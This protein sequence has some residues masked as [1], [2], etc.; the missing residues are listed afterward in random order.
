[1]SLKNALLGLLSST[2]LNGY[3][4]KLLFNEAVQFVWQAELSQIYRELDALEKEGL[5][6]STIEP[7]SDRPNKR[8]YSIT[9]AGRKSFSA[10]LA[11]TPET[12]AMPKRDEFLLKLFF[13]AKAGDEVV[14]RQFETLLVQMREMNKAVREP[15]RIAERYPNNPIMAKA[16][17]VCREDRYCRFIRTRAQITSEAIIRWAEACLAELRGGEE[18][19]GDTQ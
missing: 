13:G 10:W 11:E 16:D 7:Q 2:P 19:K 4:I 3:T 18:S 8:V 14:I 15:S 17:E 5:V 1:M 9:E 6:S 12:F